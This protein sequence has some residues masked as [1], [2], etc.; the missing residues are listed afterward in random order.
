MVRKR[1]LMASLVWFAVLA[2]FSETFAM[3]VGDL[4]LKLPFSSGTTWKTECVYDDSGDCW[5]HGEYIN[6][7]P[8]KDRYALDFNY[9]KIE[10]DSNP[11][12]DDLGMSIRAA[13]SGLAEVHEGTTGY[14]NYVLVHHIGGYVTRYAHLQSITVKDK[15][16]I[17]RGQEIGKCG[18]SGGYSPHLH[19][20]L[21]K[22][23]NPVKPEP[24]DGYN[25]PISKR[26]K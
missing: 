1:K 22:D 15:T 2:L 12:D 3:S 23:G 5:T 8:N 6:G 13:A 9:Y 10:P 7:K 21:Y 19:F 11:S 20:A 24:M 18:G 16:W 17:G 14:G 4:H 25:E 26:T